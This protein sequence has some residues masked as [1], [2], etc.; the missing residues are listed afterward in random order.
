MKAKTVEKA[1]RQ[2][3]KKMAEESDQAYV[4]NIHFVNLYKNQRRDD[5][6]ARWV[7]EL[8]AELTKRGLSIVTA[9]DTLGI[10]NAH[11]NGLLPRDFAEN[12]A[13]AAAAKGG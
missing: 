12:L 9:M 11:A 2:G 6:F 7:K 10:V 5:A 13:R 4:D 3:V 8:D 1:R